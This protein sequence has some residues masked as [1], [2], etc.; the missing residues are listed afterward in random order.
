MTITVADIKAWGKITTSSDDA[1]IQAVLDAVVDHVETLHDLPSSYSPAA[2]QAVIMQCARLWK[3]RDTPEG[4]LNFQDS[5]VIRI[6][7]LDNDVQTMLA[8]FRRFEFA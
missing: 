5:G 6:G 7:N 8:P 4:V 1:L 3:R 2:R